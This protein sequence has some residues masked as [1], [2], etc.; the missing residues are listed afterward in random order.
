MEQLM[1][2]STTYRIA[3]GP[4]QGRKVFTLPAYEESFDEGVGQGRW[5]FIRYILV[6]H[7]CR[8]AFGCANRLSCRFVPAC[9]RGGV[10]GRARRLR[11]KGEIVPQ[12]SWGAA[13]SS[14]V[15][16]RAW[17]VCGLIFSLGLSHSTAYASRWEIRQEFRE[18]PR[19]VNREKREARREALR[20]K[21]KKC[22]HREIRE[23]HREVQREKR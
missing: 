4:Q 17:L 16:F 22:A 23:G 21:R 11:S 13:M 20:C 6:P 18:G 5:V 7:P 1:G 15:F 9:R 12:R 19:E 10:Q 3:V 8:A 2:A 14:T